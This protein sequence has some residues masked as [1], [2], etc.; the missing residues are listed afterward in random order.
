MSRSGFAD[1]IKLVRGHL[2]MTQ[3]QAADRVGGSTSTWQQYESGRSVPGG[4]VLAALAEL[5]IDGTWL[6]TGEGEMLPMNRPTAGVD[7]GLLETAID[8]VEQLLMEFDRKA[9]P[10]KKAKLVSLVYERELAIRAEGRKG[11]ST[12]EVIRL[13]KMVV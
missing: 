9:D 5:G 6:L 10:A 8:V 12:A 3:K 4:L 1:R 7:L 13:F 2:G 11:A